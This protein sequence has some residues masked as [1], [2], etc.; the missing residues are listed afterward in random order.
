MSDTQVAT[1]ASVFSPES[2]RL[3]AA[4]NE[5]SWSPYS[6]SSLDDLVLE[7]L[8][9]PNQCRWFHLLRQ[10]VLARVALGS[11]SLMVEGCLLAYAEI[12]EVVCISPDV[13]DGLATDLV[14][15]IGDNDWSAFEQLRAE[16]EAAYAQLAQKRL[17][18]DPLAKV[19]DGDV[20]RT[21]VR[22]SWSAESLL[23]PIDD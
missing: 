21:L 17:D 20:I 9:K 8:M 10:A 22:L 16:S 15:A 14:M 2:V 7:R 23:T 19:T 11:M 6:M 4:I 13:Q 18:G 1:P 12:A 3:Q 5:A